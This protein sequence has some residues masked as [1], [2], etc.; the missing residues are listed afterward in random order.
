VLHRADLEE[1][2]GKRPFTDPMPGESGPMPEIE[3]GEPGE[4]G[5]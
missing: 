3:L 2:I 5:T 4:G 1:I